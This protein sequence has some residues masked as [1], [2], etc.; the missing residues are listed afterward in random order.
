M[1]PINYLCEAVL[2]QDHLSGLCKNL[3]QPDEFQ[4]P[5]AEVT[6]SQS[7]RKVETLFHSEGKVES[8]FQFEKAETVLLPAIEIDYIVIAV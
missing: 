6:V 7:D 5:G 3:F 2:Q 8:R 1:Q 4:D